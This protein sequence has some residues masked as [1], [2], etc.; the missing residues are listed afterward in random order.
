MA[1]LPLVTIGWDVFVKIN[2]L[3]PR[4][5]GRHF[6]DNIFKWIFLNENAW[7]L[8]FIEVTSLGSNKQYSSIC[9]DDGLAPARR[10]AIILINN[11]SF[12]KLYERW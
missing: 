3:R 2:P 12:T 1:G 10:R 6:P 7:I 8:N 4:Q 11:G 5:N 9:S